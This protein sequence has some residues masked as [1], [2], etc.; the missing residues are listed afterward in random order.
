[1]IDAANANNV[2][3]IE[4]FTH[5]W[6]PHLRTARRLITEGII[7]PVATLDSSLCFSAEP[8]NNVRFSTEL[9]GGALW[10]VGC[11]AVYATRF[12][13]SSEPVRVCGIAYDSGNWGVDTTFSGT[14]G[15]ESGAIAQVTGSLE[16]PF[17]C[18]LSADG[19]KG[20]IEIPD[21]FNDSGPIIIK[22][23]DGQQKQIISTPAPYRFVV[24]LDEFSECIL[25]GKKPEFPAED[26]LRNTAVLEALYQ[27]AKSGSTVSISS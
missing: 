6:N 16:Q 24:Q 22:T 23:K 15:F 21:M 1:M 12:V 17:R 18:Q 8:K 14:M 2:L 5:R 27:S 13:L 19:P 7:G 26:G 4:A 11:Y 10:D 20:R 9:G 3:L 25:T